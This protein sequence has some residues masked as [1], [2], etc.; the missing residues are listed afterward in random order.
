MNA[1]S[2]KAVQNNEKFDPELAF[3][4]I[5][6]QEDLQVNIA[7]IERLT[8]S[9]VND[10]NQQHTSLFKRYG[11]TKVE[12]N[13]ESLLAA[14]KILE[15]NKSDIIEDFGQYGKQQYNTLYDKIDS[16]IIILKQNQ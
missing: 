1:E 8:K 13:L 6:K 11:I 15:E 16:R 4:K 12:D 7:D 2:L 3:Q 9:T 10:L 5:I 14:Q